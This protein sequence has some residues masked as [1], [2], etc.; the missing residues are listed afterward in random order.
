[1][2]VQSKT[3]KHS[4]ASFNRVFIFILV[5][6]VNFVTTKAENDGLL[7]MSCSDNK[8]T[9]NSAFQLNLRTLLLDLSSNATANKEFY[10]TTVADKNHSSNTVYG[11]F[12]CKGDVP[13]HLCSERVTN[14]TRAN[15]SSD[16][17][18]CSLSKEVVIM[19]KECMVQ[20]SNYS[21]FP[22]ADF[23]SPSISCHHVNVSNK[24]IFERLVYK[25]LNGVADEA[26]NFSIGFQKYAT[27]EA[28]VSGFQTLYFQAQC[29]PDLSPKD[30]R[31]CLNITITGVLKTCKLSNAMV[32]NSETYSCYIRYDVYPFYR[33]SN[34][35]TPQELV[36]ASNTIDS[37]YSQ[38]P[39]YLSH[40]CSINEPVNN[41][42]LSNLKTFFTSLSSNAI[43]TS[44]LKTTVDTANGLFMCRGDISISPTLCQLCIQHATKRILSECPSSK[45]AIIWYDK[46]LLRYSYHSLLSRI[47]TS[48]PKF[49]QFNLANSSNLNLLHRFTTWKL[50]DILHEVGNLQ[51]GD[52]TIKNYETR[53]VKLNDLQPIY[54]LAQC[55]PD[56]SDT[57]C[58]ACLQNI[59]QNEIPWSS[60]ASPEG[61]ILYPSCYMMFGLSQ[62]YNNDDE[63]EM[64][65]QVSPPPTIKGEVSFN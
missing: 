41:D 55:T 23:S 6:F 37:K 7:F 45:E 9:P 47:D 42:F 32:A 13:T 30:C 5:C 65:G 18:D 59:F 34:A 20:Y 53:S 52:R 58:R 46:C 17:S 21:F 44:F 43:R 50:A 64:F 28:T 33:P 36:P 26:A 60:L 49:H 19:Y 29:T 57:D 61:K 8:T 48:A 54:T 11:L 4:T 14:V 51:T 1:M 27:K 31:K 3:N 56:L 25:T 15:L 24:A 22:T 2:V 35:P 39:A 12:M 38:H 16:Y 10:N 63:P 40:N 62:F